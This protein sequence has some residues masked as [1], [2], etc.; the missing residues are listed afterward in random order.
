MNNNIDILMATFN[1][2][3][4]LNIQ[5]DSLIN[6]SY[7]S[8][9]L[10]VSDDGSSDNTVNI[11]KEYQKID[12]RIKLVESRDL[13]FNLGPAGSFI[14]LL[15][16]SKSDYVMFC[17]QDDYWFENKV[18]EMLYSITEFETSLADVPIM[19]FSSGYHFYSATNKIDGLSNMGSPKSLAE[20]LF[21]NGGI[22]GCSMII[23]RPLIE[24]AK[25][26]LCRIVMH[27]HYLS[28]CA[29]SY[30]VVKKINKPLMLY[31]HHTDNATSSFGGDLFR[32]IFMHIFT[33]GYLFEINHKAAISDF[34]D[35]NK[36]KINLEVSD[37]FLKYNNIYR[38]SYIG[39]ICLLSVYNFSIYGSKIFLI[40]K[41]LYAKKVYINDRCQIFSKID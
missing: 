37:I 29:F 1:G 3:K 38:S 35:T 30:G 36:E 39:R 17:D 5:I 8:W 27:D 28:L 20:F 32:K 16:A 41:S 7:K 2:E 19:I 26:S 25:D 21:L 12:S 14:E 24:K 10:F 18:E 11:I 23:N 31:R 22:Q 34:Y 13:K 4:Y 40:I 6:Q 33:R 9:S 15:K